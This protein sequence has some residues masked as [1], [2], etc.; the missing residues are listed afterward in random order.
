MSISA[1]RLTRMNDWYLVNQLNA[2]RAGVRGTHR[3]DL[4][5]QQMVPVG[6]VLGTEQ[7]VR[8]LVAYVSALD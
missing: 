4:F 5:G 6:D 8:D 1:P 3:D 7:A 2:Y